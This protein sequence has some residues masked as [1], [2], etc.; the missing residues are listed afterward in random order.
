M[1]GLKKKIDTLVIVLY[2]FVKIL[3]LKFL[4]PISPSFILRMFNTGTNLLERLLFYNC[5]NPFREV[6]ANRQDKAGI[7]WQVAWGKHSPASFRLI[8][9]NSWSKGLNE[10]HALPIVVT[11]DPYSWMESLCRHPYSAQWKHS[12]Q[13]CPNLIPNEVDISMG[14]IESKEE[15][16]YLI[17]EGIPLTIYYASRRKVT[18]KNLVDAWNTWYGDYI[19]AKYPRLIVR[20]E[21]L[22][23]HTEMVITQACRCFGGE[24]I[25]GSYFTY[26]VDSAKPDIGAHRGGYGLREALLKY[27]DVSKRVKSLTKDDLVFAKKVLNKT[28][29]DLFQYSVE[30]A[31]T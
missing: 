21:D 5:A 27:S 14:Y 3:K 18:H 10:M 1:N 12:Q 24:I 28:M 13:H 8:H 9:K 7:L 29:M 26:H 23:F 22:L 31:I 2:L 6:S 15:E 19:E 17:K 4:F 11:K 25:N 20:F 30:D 16:D